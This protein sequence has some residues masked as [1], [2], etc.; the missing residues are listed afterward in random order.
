MLGICGYSKFWLKK[1]LMILKMWKIVFLKIN[2]FE[3]NWSVGEKFYKIWFRKNKLIMYIR[4]W[5]LILVVSECLC[6][7]KILFF[8][9][10]KK[11]V[12]VFVIVCCLWL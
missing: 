1:E 3:G 7:G 8:L 4:L 2:F 11:I 9:F 5:Y 10:K 12:V 6:N